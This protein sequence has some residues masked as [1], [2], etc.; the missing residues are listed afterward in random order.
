MVI[1]RPYLSFYQRLHG[2]SFFPLWLLLHGK[3]YLSTAP[4]LERK[5]ET[6]A[7][8]KLTQTR[9]FHERRTQL[10]WRWTLLFLWCA[11]S[12]VIVLRISS[13]KRRTSKDEW[14][15]ESTLLE[16]DEQD[17]LKT[18]SRN[19]HRAVKLR[20]PQLTIL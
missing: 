20:A 1:E 15:S 8:A 9:N 12:I 3:H 16:R 6:S 2:I 10:L 13:G 19:R 18:Q 14:G 17:S 11:H 5:R 7:I 4:L